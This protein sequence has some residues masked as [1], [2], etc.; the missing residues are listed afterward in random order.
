LGGISLRR[1]RQQ[2]HIRQRQRRRQNDIDST[3]LA[4]GAVANGR[5]YLPEQ[6]ITDF[7]CTLN[8]HGAFFT[9]PLV[10]NNRPN[11]TAMI[12]YLASN[13]GSIQRSVPR[14]APQVG[15]YLEQNYS[16]RGLFT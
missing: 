1:R 3:S 4:I 12:G 6:Q 10:A 16:T 13:V 15:G 8:V 7:L 2:H 9:K 5:A 11:T 14:A